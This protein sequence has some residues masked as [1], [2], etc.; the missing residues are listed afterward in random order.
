MSQEREA[1]K[2]LVRLKDIADSYAA[3]VR[4]SGYRE[5]KAAAWEKARAALAAR[6]DTERP[7]RELYLARWDGP[8]RQLEIV[9]G[10]HSDEEGVARAVKL[11]RRIFT[12]GFTLGVMVEVHPLP[13]LDPAINEDAADACREM[14]PG[15]RAGE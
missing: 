1:L 13:N 4:P 9:D 8:G 6:E 15:H 14:V 3:G 12:D 2:E 7:E 5:E 11:H 10:A